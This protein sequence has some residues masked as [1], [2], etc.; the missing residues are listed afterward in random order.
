MTKAELI[1]NINR[2]LDN[3]QSKRRSAWARGV[4][5]IYIAMMMGYINHRLPDDDNRNL[6]DD[7]IIACVFDGAPGADLFDRALNASYGGNYLIYNYDIAYALCT[8]SELKRN[9]HGLRNPNSRENWC[10]VQARA[11]YQGLAKVLDIANGG[12]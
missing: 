8:P 7:D 12:G 11:I 5:N 6:S 3:Q 2:Y 4:D 9:R 10:Q 1:N